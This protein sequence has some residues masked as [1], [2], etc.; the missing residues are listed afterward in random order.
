MDKRDIPETLRRAGHFFAAGAAARQLG[1]PRHY[2]CHLGM[3][4]TLEHD[5]DEFY[6]GWDAAK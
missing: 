4:S 5:R 1:Q 3:R 2:G 6:R